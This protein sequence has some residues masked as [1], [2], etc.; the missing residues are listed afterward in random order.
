MTPAVESELRKALRRQL[1]ACSEEQVQQAL[2]LALLELETERVV[3]RM[4]APGIDRGVSL[5]PRRAARGTEAG[6]V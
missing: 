2:Q 4:T 5:A 6:G 1:K 3:E